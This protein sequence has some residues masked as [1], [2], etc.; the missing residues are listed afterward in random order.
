MLKVALISDQPTLFLYPKALLNRRDRG[1]PAGASVPV[2]VPGMASMVRSGGDLTLVAWGNTVPLCEAVADRLEQEGKSTELIDLRS[3]V[4]WD[5][6]AVIASVQR[7]RTL[8]IAHEDRRSFGIGAEICATVAEAIDTPIRIRRVTRANTF[9]PYNFSDQERV[10][11]SYNTILEACADAIGL[12]VEWV[13]ERTASATIVKAIGSGPADDIVTVVELHVSNGSVAGEGDII[14]VVEASKAAVEIRSQSAGIIDEVLCSV[15][16]EVPVGSALARWRKGNAESAVDQQIR[17]RPSATFRTRHRLT[18]NRVPTEKSTDIVIA[19]IAIVGGTRRVTT[20]EL[21]RKW[22]DRLAA[23]MIRATGIRS[24]RW[25]G[26]GQTVSGLA[27]QAF[28]EIDGRNSVAISRLGLVIATTGTPDAT[29]PSLAARVASSTGLSDV[30][31]YDINSACSGYLYAVQSVYDYLNHNPERTAVIVTSEVLSPLLDQDDPDTAVLFGDAATATLF[32]IHGA[33]RSGAG[34]LN[35]RRPVISGRPEVGEL[36]SVPLRG[37]GHDCDERSGS[38]WRGS[39]H[40]GIIGQD[41]MLARR[42]RG[43][44]FG[45]HSASSG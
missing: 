8:V 41:G 13:E 45:L 42:S 43:G 5:E 10:L 7:T 23:E 27:R 26:P 30:A 38:L 21:C 4:P 28:Q 3:L 29:T 12:E 44:V 9:I 22:P 36:L 18:S 34:R 33:D 39:S 35:L 32:C 17:S 19:D 24:R 14:A 40:D 37:G 11:P 15:G 2:V 16:D 31:T 6:K 20:E 25:I 1:S